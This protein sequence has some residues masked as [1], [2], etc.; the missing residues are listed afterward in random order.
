MIFI[1]VKLL[2]FNILGFFIPYFRKMTI[3][4]VLKAINELM[5]Q[6]G[7]AGGYNVNPAT[8]IKSNDNFYQATFE[9]RMSSGTFSIIF[10]YN[11]GEFNYAYN[12]DYKQ[13]K[14]AM[15]YKELFQVSKHLDSKI[16][17]ATLLNLFRAIRL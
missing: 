1:K 8:E 17:T 13:N 11:K 15:D 6:W 3:E 16:D 9:I 14:N 5:L 10:T 4:A 2:L 12:E 7:N